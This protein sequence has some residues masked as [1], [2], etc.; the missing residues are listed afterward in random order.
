MDKNDKKN[1]EDKKDKLE[2]KKEKA[3]IN[4]MVAK[5]EEEN[6]KF[7]DRYDHVLKGYIEKDN[8]ETIDTDNSN[9]KEEKIEFLQDKKAEEK[10]DGDADVE[11]DIEKFSTAYKTKNYIIKL[12]NL[13]LPFKG[14]I[15]LIKSNY[16][17]TVLLTFRIYRFL[18]LM[19]IFATVIFFVLC[20]MHLVKIKDK[21]NEDCKYGFKC[22]FFI[23]SFI[24]AEDVSVSVTYGVWLIFYFIC[25]MAY[26]FLL[27]SEENEQEIYYQNNKNYVASS[28]LVSSWNFNYKNEETSFKSKQAIY[29]ELQIYTK[30]FITELDGRKGRRCNPWAMTLSHFLYVIYVAFSFFVII[31]FF[32]LRD[33]I[34]SSKAIVNKIGGKDILADIITYL[35]IGFSLYFLVWL[36]GLF[37][38]YEGWQQERHKNKSEGVKK[39]IITFVYLLSMFFIMTYI[40]LYGNDDKKLLSFL[41]VERTT[42][43][44]CPGKFVDMRR[45]I[46]INSIDE[47]DFEKTSRKSYSQCREEDTGIALFFIFLIY[48]IFLYVGDL[49]KFVFTFCYTEKPSFRPTISSIKFFTAVLLYLLVIFYI[50]YFALLFPVVIVLLYKFQFFMLKKQGSYSFKETGIKQR[51]NNNFILRTFIIFNIAAFCIIGYLYFVP[52]PHFYHVECFSP[53]EGSGIEESY[54]VYNKTNW[55]GPVKSFVRL[56]SVMTEQM[57]DTIGIG[58]IVG[59]IQQFPFVIILISVVLV[60]LIYRKYNP[61]VRYY[62]YLVRRQQELSNT[63]HVFFEQ[64]SKRDI[65]TSMLLKIL[66]QKMK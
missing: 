4:K 51:N 46:S 66:Q 60:I 44:G 27:N 16:S 8:A 53:K 64:I 56:S 10:K 65:L 63:F 6:E 1:K 3:K 11:I 19:S 61:D 58:Y 31:L 23:S 41:K 45:K 5:I 33:T 57:E 59:L 22:F 62:D 7:I 29:K 36:C 54:L 34:R 55:C 12:F 43:F 49:L 52:F 24:Q 15:R 42:F 40:T 35:F 14:D 37:P 17:T 47:D 32:W 38:K 20:I 39:M 18:F 25:T 50:P 9:G 21:L 2:K 30:N 28:Y 13:L 48:Y 26:Y